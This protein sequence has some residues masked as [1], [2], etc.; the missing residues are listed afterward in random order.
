M[1]QN[2]F[3]TVITQDEEGR[4]FASHV[5]LLYEPEPKPSGL[6][7]GHL[8]RANPQWRHFENHREALAI[9]HGPH[10]YISPRWYASS[11]AV[12]TWNYAVVHA[13]GTPKIIAEKDHLEALVRRMVRF[14]E[15]DDESAWR[16]E[17]PSDFMTKQLSAIV[18]FEIRINRLE[19]KFKLGQNRQKADL[20]GV[21][22]ALS[23]SAR[24][25]D[26]LLAEFMTEEG[27][28]DGT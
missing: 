28:T 3:A 15:G 26:R 5:P 27:L 2:S 24:S 7:I 17:L 11:P 8:A 9:F 12:P 1:A 23:Q 22:A 6:L 19:G 14:Y 10:A 20:A 16:G 21:Y 25:E 13:Y 4:P 18:G